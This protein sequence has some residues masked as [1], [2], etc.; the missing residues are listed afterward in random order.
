M[1]IIK[2]IYGKSPA[3]IIWGKTESFYTLSYGR[4]QECLL[5]LLLFN[6]VLKVLGKQSDKKIKTQGMQLEINKII[7]T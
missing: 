1:K 3:N 6:I 2:A 7:S 4:R 5:S